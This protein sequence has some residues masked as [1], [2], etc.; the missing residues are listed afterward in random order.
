VSSG[1]RQSTKWYVTE[2][3]GDP[4][5]PVTTDL[6]LVGVRTGK[7]SR[8]AIA[9]RV[10]ESGWN[11]IGKYPEFADAVTDACDASDEGPT[12]RIS[13]KQLRASTPPTG[14]VEEESTIRGPTW[15]D[16]DPPAE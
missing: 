6:L 14:F 5:G 16:S 2:G 11:W 15:F 1:V 10:G 4:V 9:C 8:H 3:N 7:V 12:E 13:L